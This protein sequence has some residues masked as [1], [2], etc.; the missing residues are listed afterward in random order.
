MVSLY[1]VF[2]QGSQLIDGSVI[3]RSF[4][5]RLV[6]GRPMTTF[7]ALRFVFCFLFYYLQS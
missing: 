3:S 1:G 6:A 7:G 2:W 5:L 4:A